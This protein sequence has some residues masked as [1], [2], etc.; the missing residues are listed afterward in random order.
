MKKV[1]SL[2]EIIIHILIGVL[3]FVDGI[4]RTVSKSVF[5]SYRGGGNVSFFN[6][7]V[8]S[9]TIDNPIAPVGW[10]FIALL[11]VSCI[12]L[13]LEIIDI[14]SL[15]YSPLI[16]IF[17]LII[18]IVISIYVD[19]KSGGSYRYEGDIRRVHLEM[20]TLFYVEIAFLLMD[21]ALDISKKFVTKSNTTNN[22]VGI[23]SSE[24][25]ENSQST[26]QFINTDELEKIKKL[27]DSGIITQ[28][29]FDE[30]KKQLLDL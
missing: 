11:I 7:S 2:S 18:F 19:S 25:I 8:N 9:S 4:Y 28:D 3:L 24:K 20:G 27:L 12:V 26:G 21:I 23:F 10:I 29:E 5:G 30:K 1:I 16:P 14:K 22:N 13:F 6:C 17:M 15:K